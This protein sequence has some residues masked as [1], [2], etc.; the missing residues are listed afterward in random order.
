MCDKLCDLTVPG[1]IPGNRKDFL[2]KTCRKMKQNKR[3][4]SEKIPKVVDLFSFSE[5]RCVVE[6]LNPYLVKTYFC[7]L[8]ESNPAAEIC[9]GS[10]TR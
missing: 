3:V 6:R 8:L 9:L 7:L 5:Q 2:L 1:S 4:G 10:L